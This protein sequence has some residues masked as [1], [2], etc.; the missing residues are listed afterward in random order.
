MVSDPGYLGLL[1]IGSEVGLNPCCNGRWSLT[2]LSHVARFCFVL[3]LVVMEDGLWLV[4]LLKLYHYEE[5]LN[6]CC[7]GRWSLTLLIYLS[8]YSTSVLILVVMEDGLWRSWPSNIPLQGG[9]NPCCNGRW[10]LTLHFMVK[11][12]MK[13]LNP[14]CNGRWSLTR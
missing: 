7:N 12:K 1:L 13:C 3:I 6:P 11:V 5:C 14:C 8:L 2:R 4:E 9:L 10:S